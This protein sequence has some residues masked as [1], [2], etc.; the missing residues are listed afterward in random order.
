MR[1]FIVTILSFSLSGCV[2]G[3]SFRYNDITANITANK[4]TSVA[5]ATIDQRPYVLDEDS[6]PSYAGMVR[7]PYAVPFSAHTKSGKALA[8]EMT[9][10]IVRSLAQNGVTAT[11]VTT[12][13]RDTTAQAKAELS[14]AGTQRSLLLT[15]LNWQSDTLN[16]T[17]LEYDV[18][19][20]VLGESGKSIAQKT[21]K[22][23]DHLGGSFINPLGYAAKEVPPAVSKVI[24][25]F[26]ASEEIRN[27]LK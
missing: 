1:I 19:L 12:H 23:S 2:L 26:F 8:D 20:E 11:S 6:E 4:G 16:N 27:A 18:T 17:T 15:L 5:V 7:G 21:F 24:G 25:E 9:G 14:A 22:G 13:F 3:N 10:I